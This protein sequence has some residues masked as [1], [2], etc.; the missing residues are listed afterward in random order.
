MADSVRNGHPLFFNRR[1]GLEE[2]KLLRKAIREEWGITPETLKRAG[3]TIDQLL[4]DHDPRCKLGAIRTLVAIETMVPQDFRVATEYDTTEAL[5]ELQA[6]AAQQE[7][8]IRQLR[9][10]SPTTFG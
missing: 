1:R 9:G 6:K 8:L 10:E 2:L 4:S 7:E 5:R 3:P